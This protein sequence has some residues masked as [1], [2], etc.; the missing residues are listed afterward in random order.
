MKI[1][2]NYLPGIDTHS[3]TLRLCF[4]ILVISAVIISLNGCR[5]GAGNHKS[6]RPNILVLISD[7]QRWDQLSYADKPLIPELRTPNLDSLAGQGVYFRNAFVTT[8]ICAVSRASIM[9][10]RYASTHG[11]NHFKTPMTPDVLSKCYP[12]LLHDN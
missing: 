4:K 6:K 11:M 5:R 8:P 9:T 12:A 10:G 1:L 2:T 3:F 7:D